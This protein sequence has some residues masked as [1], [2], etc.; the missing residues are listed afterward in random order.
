[1][2]A[3][4]HKEH[5]HRLTRCTQRLLHTLKV[6]AWWRATTAAAPCILDVGEGLELILVTYGDDAPVGQQC[7]R[8]FT[9]FI[10]LLECPINQSNAMVSVEG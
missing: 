1:M 10:S 8:R 4:L 7:T 3:V 6:A 5:R 2:H 9:R